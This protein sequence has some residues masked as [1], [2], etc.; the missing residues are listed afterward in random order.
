MTTTDI[1]ATINHANAFPT[2]VLMESA[3][4]SNACEFMDY[5][6][7]RLDALPHAQGRGPCKRNI[8]GSGLIEIEIVG[9][10]VVNQVVT[11]PW[12]SPS[13]ESFLRIHDTFEKLVFSR[14]FG[15]NFVP[16]L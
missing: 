13:S 5:F 16:S 10:V 1:S 4:C 3:V 11:L 14:L 7:K 2:Q 6:Q 8:C 15:R 12:E 9:Q